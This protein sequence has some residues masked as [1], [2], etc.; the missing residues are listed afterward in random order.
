MTELSSA[1][2]LVKQQYQLPTLSVC[3]FSPGEILKLTPEPDTRFPL[4]SVTKTFTAH[5]CLQPQ[6]RPWLDRPIRDVLAYFRLQDGDA[7]RNMTPRDALCHFSGLAPHPDAWVRSTLP[8]E[9]FI[10]EVLPT[11]PMAGPFREQHRYSNIM[12]AVL[13]QWIGAITG[14]PWE[15]ETAEKIL[16]PLRLERTGFLDEHWLTDA[17]PPF[18]MNEEGCPVPMPPFF[19]RARHL[20]APASEMIGSMPDLALWGQHMLTLDPDDL[21]WQPHSLISSE[22]PLHYGLGWRLEHIDGETRVWHSGQCSGYSILLSLYP[23]RQQGLAAATNCHASVEALQTL[24]RTLFR[25]SI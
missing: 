11:L 8:R 10:R 1:I 22:G 21:R 6:C 17:A 24:D 5:L 12:Y 9:A 20:I 3:L 13:G 19:A 14:Q 2:N 18:Q 4:A 15:E 23:R 25:A 16:Q 7:A